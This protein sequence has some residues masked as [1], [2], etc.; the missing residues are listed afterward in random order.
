MAASKKRKQTLG[1][2]PIDHRV[3]WH[4]D[5]G[6]IKYGNS[7]IRLDAEMNAV[8]RRIALWHEALHALLSAAGYCDHDENQLTV[9]AHGIVEILR[10]NAW[11]RDGSKPAV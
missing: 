4:V 11:L 9:L 2:G 7:T 10:D 5:M 8:P 1:I 6:D 3:K